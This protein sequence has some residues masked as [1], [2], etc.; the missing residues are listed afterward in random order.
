MVETETAWMLGRDD[1]H[2]EGTA[3]GS[4]GPSLCDVSK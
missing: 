2:V 3:G 4:N 1:R